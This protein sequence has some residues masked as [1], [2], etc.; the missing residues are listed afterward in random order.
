MSA[1]SK[2]IYMVGAPGS[3][4]STAMRM[5][6]KHLQRLPMYDDAHVARDLLLSSAGNTVAVELGKTRGAF[7]GT[8]A[9]SMSVIGQAEEYLTA[10]PEAPPIVLAEGARLSNAR[11]LNHALKLGMAV[12]VLYLDN[13]NAASWR[14]ARAEKLGKAQ[15]ES[16]AKGRATAARN[17]ATNPP[18]GVK[19]VTVTHP[20]DATR[21]IIRALARAES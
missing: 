8:D 10:L 17:L 19:V 20:D 1:S 2:L 4:K 13:P 12:T 15:S 11:F 21:K 5:A 14:A 16:W 9:L 6:T 18:E 3:G 7:A